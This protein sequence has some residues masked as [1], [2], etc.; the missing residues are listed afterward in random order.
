MSKIAVTVDQ[1]I[2]EKFHDWRGIHVCVNG[3]PELRPNG[4]PRGCLAVNEAE[5]IAE[6]V[7]YLPNGSIEVKDGEEATEVLT[8]VIEVRT[9]RPELRTWLEEHFAVTE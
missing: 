1:F 3:Q 9:D 5:G 6:F 7:R 8:G 2:E 4:L